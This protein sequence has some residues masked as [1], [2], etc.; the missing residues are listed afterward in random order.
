MRTNCR[1]SL[2]VFFC[3]GRFEFG[4]LSGGGAI[5]RR[6]KKLGAVSR[7]R[8]P[9]SHAPGSDTV[10]INNYRGMSENARLAH[11]LIVFM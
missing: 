9:G 3:V 7:V 4:A 2:D 8:G 10:Y 5:S 1:S 11:P 6:C